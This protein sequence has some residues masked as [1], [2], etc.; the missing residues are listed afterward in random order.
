MQ[1]KKRRGAISEGETEA[2]W[3]ERQTKPTPVR[4]KKGRSTEDNPGPKGRSTKKPSTTPRNGKKKN[5]VGMSKQNAQNSQKP[6]NAEQQGARK[7]PIRERCERGGGQDGVANARNRNVMF[8]AE[9]GRKRRTNGNSHLHH[10]EMEKR[11]WQRFEAARKK[12]VYQGGGSIANT[13]K[14]KI[15]VWK[16][17]RAQTTKDERLYARE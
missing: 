7:R 13:D 10:L 16:K 5:I 1:S 15:R 17:R 9:I 14:K 4:R 12:I 8:W 3:V 2:P 6:R 11:E